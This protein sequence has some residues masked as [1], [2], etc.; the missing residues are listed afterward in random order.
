M[1]EFCNLFSIDLCRCLASAYLCILLSAYQEN[2][3]VVGT[4]DC[5]F[6]RKFNWSSINQIIIAMK[7]SERKFMSW[8]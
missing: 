4:H 7:V 1:L 3:K 5:I 6:N 2:E 8:V